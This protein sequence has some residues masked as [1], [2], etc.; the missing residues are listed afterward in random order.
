MYVVNGLVITDRET[1]PGAYMELLEAIKA[2]GGAR[3]L[4][5][6]TALT[7]WQMVGLYAVTLI[8]SGRSRFV[9]EEQRTYTQ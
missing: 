6:R 8:L 7:E 9:Q 5:A 1:Q 3:L 2:R 4:S